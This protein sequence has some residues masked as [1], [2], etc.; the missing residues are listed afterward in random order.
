MPASFPIEEVHAGIVSILILVG[1]V[2]VIRKALAGG[3]LTPRQTVAAVLLWA[4]YAA[5]F[6]VPLIWGSIYP[7]LTSSSESPPVRIALALA[8]CGAL[9]LLPLTAA[10]LAPW[11]V[12]LIRHR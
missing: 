1:T 9:S 8:L 11:S 12:S 7:D 4:G 6:F 2:I 10:A 5:A 3:I